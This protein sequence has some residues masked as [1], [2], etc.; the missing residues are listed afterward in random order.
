VASH[1]SIERASPAGAPAAAR[2]RRETRWLKVAPTWERPSA[3]LRWHYVVIRIPRPP[4]LPKDL[5][6]SAAALEHPETI[7]ERKPT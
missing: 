5:L 7:N 1:A 3:G 4:A 2:C 6:S